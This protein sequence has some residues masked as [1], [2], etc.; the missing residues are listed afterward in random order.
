MMTRSRKV[1][2]IHLYELK[3]LQH[4]CLFDLLV[5]C[6]GFSSPMSDSST[7]VLESSASSCNE[8][9]SYVILLEFIASSRLG[10]KNLLKAKEKDCLSYIIAPKRRIVETALLS[11]SRRVESKGTEPV[12]S[13]REKPRREERLSAGAKLLMKSKI[14]RECAAKVV[15]GRGRTALHLW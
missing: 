1:S 14:E 12:R 4:V 7:S 3:R 6:H 10:R 13:Y 2:I 5:P 9:F 11:P 15:K 8:T